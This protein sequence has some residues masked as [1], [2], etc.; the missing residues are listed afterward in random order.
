MAGT[1]KRLA[2]SAFLIGHLAAVALWNMPECAL[3]TN[4][5]G[6][7]TEAYMFPTGLWQSWGMFAPEPAR[8]TLTLEAVVRDA[9]GLVRTHPFPRMMD[10]S[11][12]EG[13]WGYRHSKFA[14]NV[15]MPEAV[16]NR[17]YAARFVVRTLNL[18][19]DDFPVDVQ[20]LYEVRP[21]NPPTAAPDQPAPPPRKSVIETYNFPTLA[22]AMP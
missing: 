3:K 1:A 9:R 18:K 22:E 7:W 19:P 2:I 5:A 14:N 8:D 20:L 4:L 10:K 21:S 11:A 16:A 15:G 12:W 6:R 17:E 13:V